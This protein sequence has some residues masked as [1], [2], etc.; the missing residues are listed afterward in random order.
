MFKNINKSHSKTF[1]R[2]NSKCTN[3]LI[4]TNVI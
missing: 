4:N 2:K 1:T 3:T